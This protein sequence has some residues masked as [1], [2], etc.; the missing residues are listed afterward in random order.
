MDFELQPENIFLMIKTFLSAILFLTL[1]NLSGQSDSVRKYR[2]EK[3]Y[4]AS[5]LSAFYGLSVWGMNELWYKNYEHS[6]F[7]WIDDSREWLQIDKT[8][9]FLSS[10]VATRI[11]S[12]GFQSAGTPRTKSIL[13]ASGISMIGISTIE[14]FDGFSAGWGASASDLLYNGTG[15]ALFTAQTF[16]WNEERIIPKISW[17]P[18]SYAALRP[19]I[20]GN[21]FAERLLKDYNGHT[22]WLSFNIKSLSGISK[23]PPWLCFSLGYGAEGMISGYDDPYISPYIKRYRQYY[24]S[25]D[26]DL[27]K[28]HTGSK[29]INK[30][31]N[32]LNFIK[33]PFPAIVLS[34]GNFGFRPLYF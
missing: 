24:L 33:I 4:L 18:T 3:I 7:H 31:L 8:G 21:S 23:M 28:I 20:L 9:H 10:Y 6:S 1:L 26:A 25:L 17:H 19:E 11:I 5:G 2:K 32:F 30:A 16:I 14:V 29:T 22:L 15:V 13:L 34:Q 27:G 12:G